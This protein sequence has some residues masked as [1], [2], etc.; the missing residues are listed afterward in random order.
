MIRIRE[1]K[2]LYQLLEGQVVLDQQ[3]LFRT[4]IDMP[5]DLTEGDYTT[6]ILLTRGGKVVSQYERMWMCAKLGW[7]GSCST[8]HANSPSGTVSCP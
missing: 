6:R 5:A 1:S 2:G 8:C 4:R 7:K 3:T